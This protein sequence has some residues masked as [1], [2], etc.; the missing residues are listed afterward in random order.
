LKGTAHIV[1]AL[2]SAIAAIPAEGEPGNGLA[3]KLTL[4]EYAYSDYY[5]SDVNLRWR[6]D[7]T[8]A[9]GAL[10]SDRVFGTQ[11]RAGAERGYVG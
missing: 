5:G 1:F 8:S 2:L 11:A 4:G 10:Y 7:D 3:W 6:S 9:W